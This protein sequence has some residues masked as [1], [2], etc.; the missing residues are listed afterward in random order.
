MQGQGLRDS[1]R[2]FDA[3]GAVIL[4]A[5]F[6]TTAEN[7]AFSD[8]QEFPFRLLSDTDR[9]VGRAYEVTRSAGE[10]YAQYP[11]RY[12]YLIDPEGVIRRSYDVVDVAGHAAVVLADISVLRASAPG[13]DE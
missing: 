9:A 1:A 3:L 10:Q 12:S 7:L 6:D 2:E 5:S 13:G 4:G 11:R 8:A